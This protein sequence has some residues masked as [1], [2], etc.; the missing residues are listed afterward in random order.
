MTNICY[1]GGQFDQELYFDT[2]TECQGFPSP[3]FWWIFKCRVSLVLI[4]YFFSKEAGF[5]ASPQLWESVLVLGPLQNLQ[6]SRDDS[7]FPWAGQLVCGV[8]RHGASSV[9]VSDKLGC[10]QGGWALG[11]A[12]SLD[13]QDIQW[14]WE[15]LQT[16][17]PREELWLGRGNL[18]TS[19]GVDADPTPASFG[20]TLVTAHPHSP[21]KTCV[22]WGE[23]ALC[24]FFLRSV[25]ICKSY[26]STSWGN[27][28]Q[29]Q[30]CIYG[31]RTPLNVQK[32]QQDFVFC[33]RKHDCD[34]LPEDEESFFF[35]A[36]L[37]SL[38][39]N[40]CVHFCADRTWVFKLHQPSF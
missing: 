11:K 17:A 23:C 22:V 4:D 3:L 30:E 19:V 13:G 26:H 9:L 15:R 8:Q 34:I 7:C 6:L 36:K 1:T 5:H 27:A 18:L 10:R 33:K 14:K 37:L 32:T 31:K 25:L 12:L 16:M 24:V 35:D 38:K 20:L 39:N 2:R 21:T 40:I 29:S 28:L